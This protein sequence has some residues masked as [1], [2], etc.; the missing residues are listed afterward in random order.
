MTKLV[1]HFPF[2]AGGSY[3]DRRGMK[4]CF[5]LTLLFSFSAMSASGVRGKVT[6]IKECSSPVMVWL[7]LD[8]ENYKERLLLMHTE[9]PVGGTY[10]FYLKPGEYQ[11][12]ASDEKGCEFFKRIKVE[13]VVGQV[14]VLM[15]KK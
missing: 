7:S 3:A 13:K 10:Q 9:V 14:D 5:L 11:V 15:E 4:V 8:K 6:S 1:E 2:M 12:R